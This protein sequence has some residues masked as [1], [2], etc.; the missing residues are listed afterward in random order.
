MSRDN[1]VTFKDQNLQP[2][3]TLFHSHCQH[4]KQQRKNREAKRSFSSGRNGE[5]IA[6]IFF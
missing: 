5:K 2:V 3:I 4:G 6:R 1:D